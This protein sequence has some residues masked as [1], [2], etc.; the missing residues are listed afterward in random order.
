MEVIVT[1][2]SCMDVDLQNTLTTTLENFGI[3][4]L[5]TMGYI[6]PIALGFCVT[7]ALLTLALHWFKSITGL[8]SRGFEAPRGIEVVTN[9][10]INASPRGYSPTG[11]QLYQTVAN[12]YFTPKNTV[13]LNVPEKNL[14]Q[15]QQEGYVRDGRPLM[16]VLENQFNAKDQLGA[17]QTITKMA[18]DPAYKDYID[19][20]KNLYK[21][22]FGTDFVLST[23]G[24]LKV[25]D[26][27]I[28]TADEL[29]DRGFSE[30]EINTRLG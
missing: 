20:D 28:G 4:S 15:I 21:T 10:M 22:F 9:N 29:R 24:K 3:E 6:F 30:D 12:P 8:G 1:L 25:I 17:Q 5:G 14:S 7:M 11:T 18:S 19:S 23:P 16:A 27:G 13:A 26:Y 2:P